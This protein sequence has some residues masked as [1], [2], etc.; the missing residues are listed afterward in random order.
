M[1]Q[2]QEELLL[3]TVQELQEQ[4][5]RYDTDRASWEEERKTLTTRAE[6]AEKNYTELDSKF[7]TLSKEHSELINGGKTLPNTE[8]DDPFVT[9]WKNI[10]K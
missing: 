7:N 3:K 2:E 9:L 6:T 8:D 10:N 1:T 4:N 5:K